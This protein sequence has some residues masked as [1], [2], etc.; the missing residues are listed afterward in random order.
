MARF[1]TK[2]L[3]LFVNMPCTRDPSEAFQEMAAAARELAE[4]LGATLVDQNQQELSE[5]G[6]DNIHRQVVQLARSMEEEGVVPG[7]EAAKRLF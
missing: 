5:G 6:L 1:S 4:R 7:S 2:G 3:T